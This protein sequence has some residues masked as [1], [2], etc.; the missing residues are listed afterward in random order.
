MAAVVVVPADGHLLAALVP[1][2]GLSLYAPQMEMQ[3]DNGRQAT[4]R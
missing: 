4:K 1:S 3:T 2:S